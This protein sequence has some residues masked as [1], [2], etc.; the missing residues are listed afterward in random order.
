MLTFFTTAKPFLGH[1]GVIQRNAL[2]SWKLLHPEVE[3]ILLGDDAGAA[4]VAE[5]LKL[6]HEAYVERSA[7][8]T[9]RLD[10]VFERAQEIARHEIVC[11]CNCDILLMEDFRRAV[12]QVALAREKFLMVGRR[13]DVNIAQEFDFARA[14][15]QA[16]LR[17]LATTS[18]RQRGPEWIDYFVFRRGLYG[19]DMP[20]MVLGRVHWDNWLVWK[21]QSEGCAV[22]DASAAVIAAHQNHDYGYHPWGKQG[23]WNDEEAGNNYRLAG[24]WR[25]L[26]TIADANEVLSAVRLRVNRA[27]YWTTAKRYGR[28]AGRMLLHQVAERTWFWILG[29]TRPVRTAA[30]LRSRNTRQSTL[31]MPVDAAEEI[32][33]VNYANRAF[34][35]R[36]GSSKYFL[37]R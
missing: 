29:I 20:P 10:Y 4:E 23:V 7:R 30:G 12:E 37:E 33:Q 2:K 18:A 25:H 28:Q 17:K 5:E 16:G 9:K 22:V 6:R 26:R 31:A 15:W 27:R 32:T 19:G 24:G 14:D 34:R 13:W 35:R 36:N 21:A 3:V 1:N 11:Y 8:G